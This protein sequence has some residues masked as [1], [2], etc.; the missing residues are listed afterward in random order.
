M[1]VFIVHSDN[2]HLIGNITLD[3]HKNKLIVIGEKNKDYFK[4]CK[5]INFFSNIFESK[6]SINFPKKIILIDTIDYIDPKGIEQ[7]KFLPKG[8]FFGSSFNGSD[9]LYIMQVMG[10][11]PDILNGNWHDNYIDQS[12]LSK[13]DLHEN[14]I[15]RFIFE[16]NSSIF[17]FNKYKTLSKR[18]IL[19][20]DS[21]FTF[22]KSLE[23]KSTFE[24][25]INQ[26]SN[27]TS[28]FLTSKIWYLEKDTDNYSERLYKSS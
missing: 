19:V 9:E 4:V 12:Y 11:V 7:I 2:T 20:T 18:K 6:K 16:K 17:D 28:P 1:T 8:S 21:V 3:E 26:I 22:K 5:N 15:E 10:I 14:L 25:V 23:K 27:L 13:T 24:S